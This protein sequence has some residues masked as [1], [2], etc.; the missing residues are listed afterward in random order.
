MNTQKIDDLIKALDRAAESAENLR[1][2]LDAKDK[3]GV[4]Q[5]RAELAKALLA[6]DQLAKLINR[7]LG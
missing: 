1:T 4:P 7:E 3:V 5:E 6:V 2:A